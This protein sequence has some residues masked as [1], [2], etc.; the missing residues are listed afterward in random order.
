MS[1]IDHLP[2]KL[3]RKERCQHLNPEGERCRLDAKDEEFIFED[4]TLEGGV[5]VVYLCP[6]HY[7]DRDIMGDSEK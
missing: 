4:E 3:K 1:Y 6:K 7:Q 5:Y 2:R